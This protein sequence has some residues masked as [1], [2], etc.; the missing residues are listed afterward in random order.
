M[1]GKFVPSWLTTPGPV[2]LQR[3]VRSKSDPLC[4]QVE[5][6]EANPSY[7]HIRHPDRRETTVSLT[8]LAHCPQ[9]SGKNSN[10]GTSVFDDNVLFVSDSSKKST[11]NSKPADNSKNLDV[12]LDRSSKNLDRSIENVDENRSEIAQA[13]IELRR[14]SRVR[15]PPERYGD[16]HY[17]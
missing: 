5:L 14:S 8:D 10:V 2:L 3:F 16:C 1:L 11:D 4:D 7:A 13:P 6:I 9:A 12:S 15:R 17:Y